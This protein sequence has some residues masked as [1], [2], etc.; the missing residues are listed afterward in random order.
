MSPFAVDGFLIRVSPIF[1][2]PEAIPAIRFPRELGIHYLR[3]VASLEVRI[4]GGLSSCSAR[5]LPRNEGVPGGWS[6]LR[7]SENRPIGKSMAA[8]SDARFSLWNGLIRPIF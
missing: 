8:I 1:A 2:M 5:E 3:K 7:F 6:V 4:A